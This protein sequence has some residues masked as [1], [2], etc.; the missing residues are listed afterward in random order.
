MQNEYRVGP[1]IDRVTGGAV[2]F[3]FKILT[4]SVVLVSTE[5]V[6]ISKRKYSAPVTGSSPRIFLYTAPPL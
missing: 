5:N 1:S 6:N 4:F 3:F 2:L